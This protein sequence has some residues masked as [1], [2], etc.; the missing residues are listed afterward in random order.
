LGVAG[1]KRIAAE[2]MQERKPVGLGPSSKT[3]PRWAS[4]LE[5]STSV[6][7]LKNERSVSKLTLSCTMGC[8]K[9]GHP[10]PDSYLVVEGKSGRS[11]QTQL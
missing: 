5:Q 6:R 8:Q 4:H 10:V 11:Q 3:W 1:S 9:L 7:T 2:F